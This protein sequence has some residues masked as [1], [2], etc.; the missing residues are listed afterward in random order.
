MLRTYED[1]V[2]VNSQSGKIESF[3]LVENR[4]SV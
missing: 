4:K 3:L 2:R 1:V